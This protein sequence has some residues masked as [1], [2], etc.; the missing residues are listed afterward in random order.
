M[1]YTST[2]YECVCVQCVF[3]LICVQCTL[4]VVDLAVFTNDN[5]LQCGQIEAV[6]AY[7]AK[8]SAVC[9]MCVVCS[10]SKVYC[11]L[12]SGVCALLCAVCK[13]NKV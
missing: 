6:L 11:A 9:N 3:V 2:V 7:V 12:Q 4:C 8:G 10:A 13:I 5:A 1:Q